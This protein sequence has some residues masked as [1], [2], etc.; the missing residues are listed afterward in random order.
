MGWRLWLCRRSPLVAVVRSVS[1]LSRAAMFLLPGMF[2]LAL[3]R[4]RVLFWPEIPLS[5]LSYRGYMLFLGR[6]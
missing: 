5:G 3:R 2:F 6:W 1:S 4:R